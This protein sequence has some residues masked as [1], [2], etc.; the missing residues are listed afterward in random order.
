MA[1]TRIGQGELRL[2]INASLNTAL[3]ADL[4][5]RSEDYPADGDALTGKT[6]YLVAGLS[7]T[8][9][10]ERTAGTEGEADLREMVLELHVWV[11]GAITRAGG[12]DAIDAAVDTALAAIEETTWL[13]ASTKL[14]VETQQATVA[15]L[16]IGG[17]SRTTRGRAISLPGIVIKEP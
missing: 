12:D 15:E 1:V 4:F 16:E 8:P 11:T 5:L 17:A 14:R 2:L 3:G 9:L 7:T 10:S 6:N 13:D